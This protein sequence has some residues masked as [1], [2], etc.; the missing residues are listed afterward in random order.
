MIRGWGISGKY[1]TSEG[2]KDIQA[3]PYAT[4]NPSIWKFIWTNPFIPKIDIFCW[5]LA[6]QSI[7][8]GNN[9]K[10]RGMEGPSHCPLCKLHEETMDHIILDCPFAKEVWSQA[11]NLDQ[12]IPL[13]LSVH[14]LFS[15]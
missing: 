8:T 6:H 11:L 12:A 15:C 1:S 3:I 2:Y 13:P 10:K 14:Q 5:S 4:P 7:L 9:L